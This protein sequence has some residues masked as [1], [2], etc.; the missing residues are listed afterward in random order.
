MHTVAPI[1]LSHRLSQVAQRALRGVKGA[2]VLSAT[3]RGTRA[4]EDQRTA[5]AR[6]GVDGGSTK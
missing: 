6:K 5:V 3:Q 4:G 1:F 2:K